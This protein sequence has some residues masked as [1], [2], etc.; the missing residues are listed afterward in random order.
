MKTILSYILTIIMLQLSPALVCAE[1]PLS[2]S[3]Q[4]LERYRKSSDEPPRSADPETALPGR[5]EKSPLRDEQQTLGKIEVPYIAYEGGARRVIIPVRLNNSVTAKM[6]LDTGS[7]GMI[8]FARLASRLGILEKD[9]G[10]LLT[11]AA[12]IGGTTPAVLTIIDT[13]QVDRAADSFVPTVV[14]ESLTN[15][16]DGLIGMDFMANY[17]LRIDTV[18][19]VVVFEEMTDAKQKPGGHDEMWWRSNF[20]NFAVMRAQ[21][22]QFRE[23]LNGLKIDPKKLDEIKRFADRQYREADKLFTKLNSYA[24]NNSVPMQWREY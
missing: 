17:S 11:S 7:P 4:D 8:I 5:R 1:T 10:R 24:I 21:W 2:F 3:D 14:T 19:R 18:R 9:D 6:A 12:G 13:V 23:S 16:F 22:K 20:R 15:S